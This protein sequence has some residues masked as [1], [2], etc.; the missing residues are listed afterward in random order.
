MLSLFQPKTK[1]EK[2]ILALV[3]KHP[4]SDSDFIIKI[5]NITPEE[6]NSGLET[7]AVKEY[8][9]GDGIMK[10]GYPETVDENDYISFYTMSKLKQLEHKDLVTVK[11]DINYGSRTYF[12]NAAE[13]N[14]FP[15]PLFLTGLGQAKALHNSGEIDFVGE[16]GVALLELSKIWEE[17]LI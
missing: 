17:P 15:T 8:I 14:G 2:A 6:C 12:K 7:L 10:S 13:E 3:I 9:S 16:I 5:L 1:T 11:F 4:E